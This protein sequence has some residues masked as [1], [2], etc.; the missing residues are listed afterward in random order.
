MLY[1]AKY[2]A[3]CVATLIILYVATCVA[4]LIILSVAMCVVSF[5]IL[6]VAMSV[7]NAALEYWATKHMH[8]DRQVRLY[9]LD[10]CDKMLFH[11]RS[12]CIVDEFGKGTLTTDGVGLLAATLHHFASAPVPPKLLACTHFSDL[13][14]QPVLAR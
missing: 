1:V 3:M 6:S 11:C 9:L 2:V 8:H 10:V 4:T 7:A 13:L 5:I 12:L 14:N